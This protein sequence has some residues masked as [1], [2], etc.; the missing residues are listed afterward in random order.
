[1]HGRCFLPAFEQVE[2]DSALVMSFSGVDQRA[3]KL[4][5]DLAALSVPNHG[6]GSGGGEE[7]K[8]TS[9]AAGNGAT[10]PT[11]P[12]LSDDAKNV[13]PGSSIARQA[14]LLPFLSAYYYYY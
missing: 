11:Q 3:E 5:R 12:D 2:G 8:E 14:D 13:P 10:L 6:G 1:M 9:G 7:G 4:I